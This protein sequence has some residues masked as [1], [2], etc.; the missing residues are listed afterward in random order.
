MCVWVIKALV[1]VVSRREIDMLHCHVMLSHLMPVPFGFL[2]GYV[3]AT[4]H[5][6]SFFL[7]LAGC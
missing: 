4:F 2:V 1:P 3:N 6:L 7:Y 5:M